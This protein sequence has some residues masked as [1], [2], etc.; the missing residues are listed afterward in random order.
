MGSDFGVQFT[1]QLS[2]SGMHEICFGLMKVRRCLVNA[3]FLSTFSQ[4]TRA[5]LYESK[6]RNLNETVLIANRDV[7]G[8]VCMLFL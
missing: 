3:L 5:H 7:D 8:V 6:C 4:C 1:Q 2:S